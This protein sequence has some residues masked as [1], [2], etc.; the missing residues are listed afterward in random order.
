MYL[1]PRPDLEAD[2]RKDVGH[3][4]GQVAQGLQA[5]VHLGPKLIE[6]EGGI[7]TDTHSNAVTHPVCSCDVHSVTS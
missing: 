4:A 6:D 1:S 2:G 7:P 5:Q 3:R